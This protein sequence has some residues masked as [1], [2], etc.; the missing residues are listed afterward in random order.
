MQRRVLW[1]SRRSGRE[2]VLMRGKVS[3][4]RVLKLTTGTS[5]YRHDS[6]YRRQSNL[7]LDS[8]TLPCDL[9]LS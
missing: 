2:V 7:S 3:T 1:S 4:F 6:I 5:N 8:V 9:V